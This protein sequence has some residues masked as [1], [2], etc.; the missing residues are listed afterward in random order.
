MIKLPVIC[1]IIWK[2][3]SK[4]IL[5]AKLFKKSPTYNLYTS[6]TLKTENYK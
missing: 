1:K 3:A 2:M 6:S 5:K 4:K